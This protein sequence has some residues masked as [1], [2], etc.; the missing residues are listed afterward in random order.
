[1]KNISA[2]VTLQEIDK[3][4]VDIV[5]VII[6][7]L[8]CSLL[9]LLLFLLQLNIVEYLFPKDTQPQRKQCAIIKV[10]NKM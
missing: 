1:M 9:L 6:I 4:V 3:A 2:T 8:L 10:G 5:V 7:L